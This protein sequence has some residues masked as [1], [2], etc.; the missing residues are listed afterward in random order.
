M[1]VAIP[2]YVEPLE[3]WRAWRVGGEDGDLRLFSV[4]Q[5][6]VW[7]L[8]EELVAAC[9]KRRMLARLRRGRGHDAPAEACACGIYATSLERLGSYLPDRD[10]GRTRYVFGRVRLWGTVIE[11]EQGWRGSCAYPS[12]IL[13]PMP[14]RA[15]RAV[16]ADL[17]GPPQPRFAGATAEEIEDALSRYAVPVVVYPY[18]PA[19]ALE[20]V[21]RTGGRG[22][23]IRSL[24]P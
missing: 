11:C 23:E 19:E 13:V 12:E 16:R 9:L 15:A 22:G 20:I 8:R 1:S 2:D 21:A 5:E 17:M 24:A 7:P 10:D 3:G 18:E 6:T 4:I 14:A